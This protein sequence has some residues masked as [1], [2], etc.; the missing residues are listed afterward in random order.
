MQ[1]L[2]SVDFNTSEQHKEFGGSR[3]AKDEKDTIFF[4]SY[5]QQRNPFQIDED[6]NF[7]R[8]IE[9]GVT[10]DSAVNVEQAKEI[11]TRTLQDIKG[12]NVK[13]YSFRKFQQAVT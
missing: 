9:T 6:N 2:T 5:L 1:H 11:G 3:V 10:A 12:K 4:L 13:E 8:S 7:L